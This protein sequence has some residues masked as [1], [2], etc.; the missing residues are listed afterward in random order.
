MYFL[1][2]LALIVSVPCLVLGVVAFVILLHPLSSIA[3]VLFIFGK[4]VRKGQMYLWAHGTARFAD[5]HDLNRAGMIY[6]E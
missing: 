2:R 3:I 6:K 4:L 5:V 1:S